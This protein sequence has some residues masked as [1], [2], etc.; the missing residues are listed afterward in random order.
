MPHHFRPYPPE[1]PLLLPPDLRNWLPE[2]RPVSTVSE[3]VDA[4][5]LS[6]FYAPYAQ[7]GSGNL[8]Y[9]PAM[10]VRILGYGY[11]TG[12]LLSRRLEQKLE[13]DG[14]FRVLA[15]GNQPQ[16]RTLCEFRRRHRAACGE[17]LVAVVRDLELMS[18]ATLVPDS[19]KMRALPGQ[20]KAMSYGRM[21]QNKARLTAEIEALQAAAE[22]VNAAEDA[23]HGLDLRGDEM[24]AALQRRESRRAAIRAAQATLE[25]RA[26][27]DTQGDTPAAASPAP[28]GA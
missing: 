8:P 3:L 25:A 15:A 26:R 6:A 11:A 12:V 4:L 27:A 2:G 17:V 16:Q 28:P 5:D 20:R 19:T 24:P 23:Q 22:A 10:M 9:A 7:Q 18:L 13:E 14:A 1:Q 21:Q